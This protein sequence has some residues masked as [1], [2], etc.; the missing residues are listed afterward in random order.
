MADWQVPSHR[1]RLMDRCAH[2]LISILPRDSLCS[3]KLQDKDHDFLWLF[4]DTGRF[5]FILLLIFNV[6]GEAE[7]LASQGAIM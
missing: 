5:A 2:L 4:F 6:M 7:G 3:A 1:W